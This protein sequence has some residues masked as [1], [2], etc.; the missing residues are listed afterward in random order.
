M[1]T[2]LDGKVIQ[3]TAKDKVLIFISFLNW[4]FSFILGTANPSVN[5]KLI[6]LF[7]QSKNES[8][9]CTISYLVCGPQVPME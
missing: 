6:D 2:L 4:V 7:V 3:P 1:F 9:F 8:I 5:A